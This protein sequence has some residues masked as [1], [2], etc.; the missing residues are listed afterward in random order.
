MAEVLKPLTQ[1]SVAVIGGG[2]AGLSAAAKLA[3]QGIS[4]TLFE[5]APQ[6]GGRA[7][8]V[9]FNNLSLDNGQH[10]LLG[11]YHQTLGLLSLVG[12]SETS[13]LL[14]QPLSLHMHGAMRLK[15]CSYLPAPLHLLAGICFAMGLSFGEKLRLIGFFIWLKVQGFKVSQDLPLLDF[16]HRHCPSPKL[17]Q[18]LWEPLCLAALNTPIQQ[19]S[20]Q[21][22]LNVLRDSF[23][24]KK[25]DS[26]LLLPKTDLSSMLAEPIAT[27]IRS[28][29][30]VVMCNQA[31]NKIEQSKHG[32]RLKDKSEQTFNFSHVIVATSSAQAQN[33]GLALNVP[34]FSYQPIYTVYLQ[35]PAETKLPRIMTGF[36][37]RLSQWVFDRG[38]LCGQTGLMSV[39]I[40][41]EG[42]HQD[43]TQ[44][45]LAEAVTQE[46]ASSF[47]ELP[48]PLWH[49]VIAEK[50]ATFSC[51]SALTRPSTETTMPN[52]YLAGDYVTSGCAL[53][54]YPATIEGAVRSGLACA[55]QIAGQNHAKS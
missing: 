46:L 41:A 18:M 49:K 25:N 44:T 28:K 15:T 7:R 37:H 4:V 14:R 36:C 9:N 16:L 51:N 23:N 33:L 47:P 45:Q 48:P 19:A 20:T 42:Q 39:V 40:S 32:F 29:G 52:L 17:T 10:I 53:S 13:L 26:D 50:R 34:A 30:G 2:I 24:N 35:Y 54:D 38:A 11:A 8:R 5:A 6:L 1:K 3:E 12:I 31:I 27:Y 21:V 55:T 43:L 22:F